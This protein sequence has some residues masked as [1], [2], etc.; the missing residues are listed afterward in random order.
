[1]IR[2][3]DHADWLWW[4]LFTWLPVIIV[5]MSWAWRRRRTIMARMANPE[6]VERLTNSISPGRRRLKELMRILAMLFLVIGV[7]GPKFSSELVEVKR[8]GVDIVVLLDVSN[9]M[10]A[11]D[12]VPSRLEKAKF[13][14]RQLL[15]QLRG[16]RVA[17]VV[18]AGQAHLQTPLTL[19]YSA[20]E[21]LLDIADEKLIGVQGT[22]V[23]AAIQEGLRAFSE[24]DEKY[25]T[26][27]LI[28]D[29]EDHEGQL[30][31]ILAE[32]AQRNVIIHTAGIGSLSGTP[33]PVLD[34]NDRI[35]GYRRTAD[36]EVVT[37][38]LDTKILEEIS[39]TT[40]GRF[41]HLNNAAATLDEIYND[42]LGME[43]KEYSRHEFTNFSE[44]Y[45][46]FV[47]VALLLFAL[48]LMISDLQ[49]RARSWE[50]RVIGD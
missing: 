13:E 31:G 20:F 30:A 37:T 8:Q 12:I 32:A 49:P 47:I 25:K 34:E 29:G 50:G 41:V 39:S 18:F 16:D 23:E 46:W 22:A 1:M 27:I 35:K 38:R 21:M 17:L 4:L 48:E 36:G 6:L 44:Q 15:D 19:D 2:F 42:I 14:L 3:H 26:M 33:I 45:H 24:E 10:L 11:Q 40:S 5:L 7:T 28:S 9:S 43:Q